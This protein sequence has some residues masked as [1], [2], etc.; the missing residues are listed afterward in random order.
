MTDTPLPFSL[1]II[2]D[3][4][5]TYQ[6]PDG[7]FDPDGDWERRYVMW[8]ALTAPRKSWNAGTLDMGS[9]ALPD[10]DVELRISQTS[11]I[12]GGARIGNSRAL[13][14]HSPGVSLG[15]PWK[16]EV[17]SDITEAS[18]QVV[19]LSRISRK[20][21]FASGK[22]R[23][24]AAK[25]RGIAVSEQSISNWGLFD[26][27]QRLPFDTKPL[28][29]DLIEDLESH[30]PRHR[31]FPGQSLELT[32]GGRLVRL[33]SFEHVGSGILPYTYWLDNQH[34]LLFA[35]GGLR[36]F[37]HASTISKTQKP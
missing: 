14:T 26:F 11:K 9:R 24:E 27:V 23:W 5:E 21:G 13:I 17:E 8:V 19:P 35:I 16:W 3:Y 34:R 36:T 7:D 22:L 12:R 18:G 10:G 37:L 31:L 30:K 2:R 1:H 28:H 32:L 29:F 15:K 20:G 6:P 25:S 33:H 4:L